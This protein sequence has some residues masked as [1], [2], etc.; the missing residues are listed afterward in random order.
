M[1][2]EGRPPN[3]TQDEFD[4]IWRLYRSGYNLR[5]ISQTMGINPGSIHV[6]LHRYGGIAPYGRKPRRD[7]LTLEDREEISRGES[8]RTIAKRLRRPVSTVSRE[9][10]RNTEVQG[11]TER[12]RRTSRR[13]SDLRDRN[14]TSTRSCANMS[15]I[16]SNLTG[17]PN[18]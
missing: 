6:V 9:V 5:D 4:E 11:P 12:P 16:S 3:Y 1:N 17:L 18:R 8:M 13:L 10:G 14:S 7:R 2:R 15:S